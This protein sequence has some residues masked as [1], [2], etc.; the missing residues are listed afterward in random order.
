MSPVAL[1]LLIAVIGVPVLIGL[2]EPGDEVDGRGP[3]ALSTGPTVLWLVTAL[4]VCLTLID[5]FLN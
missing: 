3:M 5:S 2:S 1:L 4:A